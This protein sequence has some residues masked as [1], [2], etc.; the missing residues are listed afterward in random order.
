MKLRDVVQTRTDAVPRKG[1]LRHFENTLAI[2]Q[3]VCAG[4]SGRL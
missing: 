3:R 1:P 2:T 4:L